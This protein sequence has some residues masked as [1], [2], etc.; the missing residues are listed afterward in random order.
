MP[1]KDHLLFVFSH[2]KESV[3]RFCRSFVHAGH[4]GQ[5]F[6]GGFPHF[7]K[8]AEGMPQGVSSGGADAFDVVQDGFCISLIRPFPVVGDDEAMGFVA[9]E[10]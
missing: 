4:L 8:G 6:Y 1:C 3:Y 9:D 10:L 5:F 7:V 2:M